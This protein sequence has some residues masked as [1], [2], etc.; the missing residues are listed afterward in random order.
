METKGLFEVLRANED[1]PDYARAPKSFDELGPFED[2]CRV[3]GFIEL[4]DFLEYW[5]LNL[6]FH[7][8]R[9]WDAKPYGG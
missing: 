4:A 9:E 6:Q 2:Q 8:E 7:K 1:H 5:R 3:N